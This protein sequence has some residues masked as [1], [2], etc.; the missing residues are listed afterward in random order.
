MCDY[1]H[2]RGHPGCTLPHRGVLG[3]AFFL[4]HVASFFTA[5]LQYTI[6]LY[7]PTVH[8]CFLFTTLRYT[9]V[10]YCPTVHH[11]FSLLPYS[12]LLSFTALQYTVVLYCLTVHR[13]FFFTALQYTVVLLCLRTTTDAGC[14]STGTTD[15]GG[16]RVGTTVTT[17]TDCCPAP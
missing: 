5:D 2:A 11:C 7:C 13:C 15:C 17:A 8:R 6:V 1:V 12:T 3:N 4:F 10:L 16:R 9:L 14:A